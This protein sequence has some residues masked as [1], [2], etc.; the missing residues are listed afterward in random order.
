[1]NGQEFAPM[2]RQ[3]FERLALIYG[4]TMARWPEE[5]Q[6]AARRLL[7]Q[8]PGLMAVLDGAGEIDAAVEAQGAR[9]QQSIS[10]LRLSQ[11]K[12]RTLGLAM[13]VAAR[14]PQ[15]PWRL[16]AWNLSPIA[17]GVV[18]ALCIAWAVQSQRPPAN[19]AVSATDQHSL[20]AAILEFDSLS[21]GE[22]ADEH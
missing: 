12:A 9:D 7:E 20:L 6:R 17:V 4:A 21:L 5:H 8:Q 10:E 18:S 15:G 13:P 3:E 11:L 2:N 22:A 19:P 16:L 1:M 14:S